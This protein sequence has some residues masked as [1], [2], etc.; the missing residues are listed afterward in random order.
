MKLPTGIPDFETFWGLYVG[1]H[2]RPGCR[3]LHYLAAL[4]VIALLVATAIKRDWSLLI[5]AP[6]A[7]YGLAWLG[8]FAI[9]GNR[10]ATWSYPWWSLR[11]EFKMTWCA[12]RGTIRTEVR[13]RACDVATITNDQPRR[14]SP[15][16]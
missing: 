6:L 5:A 11:A 2:R 14:R 16:Q 8:H 9:E 7:A 4:S 13:D 10:P 15:A 1:E 3:A 12:L